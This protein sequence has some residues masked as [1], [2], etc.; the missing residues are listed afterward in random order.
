MARHVGAGARRLLRNIILFRSLAIIASADAGI[1][2]ALQ[3]KLERQVCTYIYHKHAHVC[4]AD[5]RVCGGRSACKTRDYHPSKSSLIGYLQRCR[6]MSCASHSTQIEFVVNRNMPGADSVACVWA[7]ACEK[8]D[9]HNGNCNVSV[10]K[11]NAP[12]SQSAQRASIHKQD[13]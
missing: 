13:R 12:E 1:L 4:N 9:H 11:R 6:H 7:F 8:P 3:P 10:I 2:Q 5:N